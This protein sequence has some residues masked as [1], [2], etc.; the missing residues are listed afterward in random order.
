MLKRLT[1]V[2][3]VLVLVL[4]CAGIGEAA[5]AKR[6]KKGSRGEAVKKLQTA[7]QELHLRIWDWLVG[8]LLLA[9]LFA[10]LT[11]TAVF[12]LSS[13]IARKK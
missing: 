2:L 10:I 9:P 11:G 5:S 3:L 1:A 8:S 13:A 4:S 7:L 12:L 6:L